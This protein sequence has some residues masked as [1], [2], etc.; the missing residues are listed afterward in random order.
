MDIGKREEQQDRCACFHGKKATL[1]V[2]ADG[3]GG[4]RG[5]ALA[6]QAVMDE[7]QALWDAEQPKAEQARAFLE[8]LAERSHERI[9]E[10]ANDAKH[11]PGATLVALLRVGGQAHWVHLGDSRLYYFNGDRCKQMTRDHSITQLLVDTGKIR[12]EDAVNHPDQSK[13]YQNLGGESDIEPEFGQATL[14]PGDWF[15]LGSDGLWQ[16]METSD[17]GQLHDYKDLEK[18]LKELTAKA[19]ERNGEE[20]DNISVVAVKCPTREMQ[21]TA[22]KVSG[23]QARKKILAIALLLY[24]ILVVLLLLWVFIWSQ[25]DEKHSDENEEPQEAPFQTESATKSQP[26]TESSQQGQTPS[27][28]DPSP[29]IIELAAKE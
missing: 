3:V 10:I 28:L 9:K 27:D 16:T 18:G 15:L 29:Q 26:Q 24:L 20:S 22:E 12:P 23:R 25:N 2:L 13:L 21:G 7:A 11:P 5:G 1:A 19:L 14:E 8:R 6:A 17:L 4:V